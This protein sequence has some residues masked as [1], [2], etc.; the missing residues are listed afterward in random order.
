M[1]SGGDTLM[2]GCNIMGKH[3]SNIFQRRIVNTLGYSLQGL[4]GTYRREEAF[5]VEVLLAL[6]LI[7]LGI[8]LGETGVEKVL[9]VGSVLFVLIVEV[10]NSAIENVVDRFGSEHDELS[11][12]AKDQGSAAV[13]LSLLLVL[14]VWIILVLN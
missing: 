10:V 2:A 4:K 11:G 7:P 8:Y 13:F 3:T 6:L 5:R 14:F 12:L 1:T 9:L